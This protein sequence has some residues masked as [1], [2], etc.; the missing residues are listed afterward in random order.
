MIRW[1]IVGIFDGDILAALK[2]L[3][4]SSYVELKYKD[5]REKSV[6]GAST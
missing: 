3:P 4:S 6:R 2:R 5:E 1:K